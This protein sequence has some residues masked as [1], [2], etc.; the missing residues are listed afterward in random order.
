[1]NVDLVNPFID[2]TLHVLKTM[3]STEAVPGKAYIKEDKQARG[4]M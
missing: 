2:A 4:V 3:S 1:M